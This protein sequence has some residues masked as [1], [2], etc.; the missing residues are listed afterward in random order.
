MTETHIKI[1][2]KQQDFIASTTWGTVFRAGIGSGKTF[3]LCL[4]AIIN[5]L[6]GRRQ[7]M[8]SFSYPMLRDVVAVTMHEALDKMGLIESRDFTYNKSDHAYRIRDTEVL[9]RSGDAPDSLRGLNMHDALIDEGRQFGD[10]AIFDIIVGRLRNASDSRWAIATTPNGNDWV[11]TLSVTAGVTLITQTTLENPFLPTEYIQHLLET[12]TGVF[13]EQEIYGRIVEMVGEIIDP[14]CFKYVP[15][16]SI[17]EGVRYWDLAVT[18]KK[19]SDWSVGALCLMSG[20]DFCLADI[21]RVKSKYPDLKEIIINNAI[22]DGR[23]VKIGLEDAG[24]QRAVIDDLARDRRL[25]NYVITARRPLGTKLARALPWISRAKLGGMKVC[26]GAWLDDFRA[27]CASFRADM[28]HPFD[29]QIDAVSGAYTVLAN[30]QT[31]RGVRI[32]L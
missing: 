26:Y 23:G 10:R 9:L 13:A 21:V 31:A 19:T 8:C 27:E 5:A 24:Q 32:H 15:T 18:D 1:T 3:V 6:N 12:Y 16:F 14:T 4:K 30:T 17:S 20:G 22:A 28:T 29:D 7:L 2:P 25:A 11:A